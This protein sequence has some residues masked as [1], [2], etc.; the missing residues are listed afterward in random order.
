MGLDVRLVSWN[1]KDPVK[2][3]REG[4]VH[5]VVNPH[6]PLDE[7]VYPLPFREFF[8]D[9]AASND[10]AVNG[11]VTNVAYT[12]QS[13]TEYDI[14]IKYVSVE[15]GDGGSPNL[16]L[17]GALPALT[18]GVEFCHF[19]NIDGFY[20]LHEGIKTNKQFIRIGTD[21]AAIGTG[22]DSFLADVSGGGSEKS[23]LPNIDFAESYGLPW[24]IRL[25]KGT[26]DRLIFKV[27]DNLTGLSTFNAIGSGIRI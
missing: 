4:S 18:N 19:N 10:M 15:I 13:S 14:Y 23:Y 3:D 7:E 1:G 12:I 8:L 20:I 17:F 25:R 6:P 16:N 11:S 5:V 2:I 22:S 26:E 27:R 21:T 9:S 24:G